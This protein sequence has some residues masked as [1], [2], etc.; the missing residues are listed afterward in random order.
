MTSNTKTLLDQFKAARRA[1]VPIVA[2]STPDPAA[3]IESIFRECSAG[4]LNGSG[5]RPTPMVEWDVIRGLRPAF[6]SNC[7]KAALAGLG[8]AV[9]EAQHP[10]EAA[11]VAARLPGD[12]EL[13]MVDGD[14]NTTNSSTRGTVLFFHLANRWLGEPA[15]I[16]A[17]WNLRDEFKHNGRM[18]VL[19]G[20]SIE[21]PAELA[22]DVIAL[23][24]PLPAAE[25]LVEIVAHVAG[26][27]GQQVPPEVSQRAVEAL[28]GLPAFAAEQ[29]TA[30]SLTKAGLD[31]DGL[32]ERKRQQIDSTPGLRVF[33]GSVPGGTG[34][35]LSEIG[36]VEVIKQFIA[37][38]MG[39][40]ARP[41]CVVFIDEIEKMLAGT[42][43]DTSG[44]AQDQLGVI[45]SYM[46]DTNATGL[47]F[48]GP[49]GSAK[50]MVA[51]AAGNL[52]GVPTIQL[53]LG[54]LKG[55]L[56]G[57]SEQQLR[58]ALKVV[59]AV[60]NSRSLWIATCNSIGELP[61]ELRRRFTLGTFFFDLPDAAER[62][63][64]W[65]IYLAQHGMP[66]GPTPND[67][68][69]TGAEIRQCCDLAWRLGCSLVEASQFV[70]PVSRSA[71]E[72]LERLRS[73]ADGKFL[74]ASRPGLYTRAKPEQETG[75]PRGR[76]KIEVA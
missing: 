34:G 19:L 46:Q 75:K 66:S 16:Q 11:R 5:G 49:P 9:E 6:D 30:M 51:K 38:V 69:W 58:A 52:A 29:V 48:I 71:A 31:L 2:I 60:S 47:I 10:I 50:S 23:D 18:L 44:V 4:T 32:W 24:E 14:G 35:K 76:R 59:T 37:R 28:T 45:L 8:S 53:D 67:D 56:V 22:G 74:S 72:Q 25:Q 3:T 17:I 70:V 1:G 41:Q 54:G 39:G 68:G 15:L 63:A 21:L 13:R 26:A 7:A 62:R 12:G 61:P 43:G 36:G 73:Q 64:I 42:R 33:R 57:Q 40:K 20:P 65:E 27:A 55:S